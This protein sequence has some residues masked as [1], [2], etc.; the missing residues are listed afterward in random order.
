MNYL[1][2][3]YSPMGIV[4]GSCCEGLELVLWLHKNTLHNFRNNTQAWSSTDRSKQP[5]TC[6]PLRFLKSFS[7]ISVI[8]LFCRSS[9]VVSS[10]M[11]LGTAFRPKGEFFVTQCLIR[12]GVRGL[13]TY[14]CNKSVRMMD[15]GKLSLR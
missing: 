5:L 3:R 4:K 6:S 2:T 7:L 11:S 15:G 13:E 1:K 14:K 10:G 12:C 9:R 8:L